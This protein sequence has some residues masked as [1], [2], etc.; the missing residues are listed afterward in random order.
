MVKQLCPCSHWGSMGNA[1]IHPQP[2]EEVSMLEQMEAWRRL[3]SSGRPGGERGPL[4]PDWSS[5]SLED[6]I[7]WKERPLGCSFGSTVCLCG[8]FTLQQ[9][10]FVCCS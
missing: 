7:A 9:G 2:V 8:Q 6:C 10:R 3:G 5:L 4:R 1:E